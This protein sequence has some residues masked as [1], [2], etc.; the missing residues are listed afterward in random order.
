LQAL[1]L[2]RDCGFVHADIKPDNIL[3]AD[4][5]KLLK[6][7]DLGSACSFED[8]DITPY[9]VSRFY[10]APELILGLPYDYAVDM[11]SLAC[12]L[13]ELYQG[14]ILFPGQSNNEMLKLH[15]RLQGK[16]S[17]KLIRKGQYGH[18]HFNN[19]FDFVSVEYDKSVDATVTRV[20]KI[21]GPTETIKQRLATAEEPGTDSFLLLEQF[22]DLLDRMLVLNPEKRVTPAKAL[23]HPFF[24]RG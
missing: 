4:D 21:V 9:L 3:V 20:L 10:R 22:V 24:G 1:A 11:W 14:R 7:A 19:D 23:E 13:Y 15:M 2:L 12:T 16:F 17:H 6:L 18:T 8:R 5:Q